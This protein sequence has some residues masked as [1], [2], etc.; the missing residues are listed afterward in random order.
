[1]NTLGK[2]SVGVVG[3]RN[4]AARLI[5]LLGNSQKVSSLIAFHPEAV[6]ENSEICVTR[7]I[8]ELTE[9]D[10]IVIASPTTTHFH[11]I[12][13]FRDYSG[14]LF[15]EKPV[16]ASS[17]EEIALLEMPNHF[18]S[19]LY[20]NY[21][22]L[23]SDIYAELKNLVQS[24]RLGKPVY[25]GIESCHGLAFKSSYKDSWRSSSRYGVGEVVSVH[26]L[27]MIS[28][29]F[30]IDDFEILKVS[31][32][33][34]SGIGN[35][36]DTVVVSS[37][38][39]LNLEFSV[40]CSYATPYNF[41]IKLIGTNAILHYDGTRLCIDEP[42]DTFDSAGRFVSPPTVYEKV[43][44]HSEAWRESLSSS[45][46]YFL[47]KVL[48]RDHFCESHLRRALLAMKPFY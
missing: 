26:F 19:R 39:N 29:L 15:V 5:T 48:N 6:S 27:N 18:K 16:V 3:T 24:S 41:H 47:D 9:C 10:A 34:N 22:F 40:L 30:D 44:H 2:L 38:G 33:N 21:N 1:M 25:L 8:D 35:A 46:N 45:V 20:V 4:H 13:K 37:N 43:I 12:K 17:K 7:N 28:Q 23:F 32:F 31:G 14:Y 36:F 11:Y 42:R